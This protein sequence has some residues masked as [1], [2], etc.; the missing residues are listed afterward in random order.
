LNAFY[1]AAKNAILFNRGFMDYHKDR[2]LFFTGFDE[3]LKP[4]PLPAN[5]VEDSVFHIMD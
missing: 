5:R 3:K 1:K 4:L 2:F